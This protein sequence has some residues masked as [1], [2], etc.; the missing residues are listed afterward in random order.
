MSLD[1]TLKSLPSGCRFSVG[2]TP[3]WYRRNEVPKHLK[4]RPFEAYVVS[5][6]IGTPTWVFESA[7]G[8]TP[9]DALGAAIT[10]AAKRLSAINP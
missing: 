1:D 2:H 4:R 10:Q 5:G 9:E 8:A 6:E 7:D 3:H